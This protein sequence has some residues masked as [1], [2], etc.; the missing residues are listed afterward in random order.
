MK[1]LH[2]IIHLDQ[3]GTEPILYHL[4]ETTHQKFNHHVVSLHGEGEYGPMLRK[5]GRV[6]FAKYES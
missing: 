6:G 3:G 2:I 1:V 5:I 4:I